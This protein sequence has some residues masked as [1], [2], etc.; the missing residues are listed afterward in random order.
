ML[1]RILRVIIP[2]WVLDDVEARLTHPYWRHR[3][4]SLSGED[5]VITKSLAS[6][7]EK[8]SSRPPFKH[9][10]EEQIL[11]YLR[12]EG[13]VRVLDVGC[14][15][16]NL[17]RHLEGLG[18]DPVGMTINPV[19][20]EAA[21]SE[22]ILL[23]DIQSESLADMAAIGKFDAVLSFDCMEHLNMPLAGLRNINRLLKPNGIFVS[24]IPSARWTECDYHIIV[25]TPRQYRWLLNLSG[26]DLEKTSGRHFFSKKGVTYYARKKC[27]DRPVYPG[28]LE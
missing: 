24:Y 26:F 15:R 5:R 27:E 20:V 21:N 19:E 6:K 9:V 22:S 2:K 3:Q 16:G 7:P 28:V 23:G 11:A 8:T 18:F 4:V 14:G 12:K 25:Y 13:V 10:D 17:V 1:K